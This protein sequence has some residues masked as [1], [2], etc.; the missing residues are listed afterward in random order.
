MP[1]FLKQ[2]LATVVGLFLFTA[3]SVA[4]LTTLLFS[5]AFLSR[6]SAPEVA[7][8]SLLTLDLSEPIS[9]GRGE[10]GDV[11][12]EVISGAPPTRSIA[13]RTV[14]E[15]IERGA[16]DDRI[17]GLYLHGNLSLEGLGSGYA[18]LQEV[19]QA[20]QKFRD[21]G[22]PI[23]AYDTTGWSERDY[24]LT[25]VANKILL[26]PA[27]QLEINGLSSETTF[28]TGALQ[29]YGIGVQP[30]RAGKYKSA[31]E[32]F[33]RTSRSPESE[34][35]T[36]A[37]LKDLWNEFVST[38]AKSRN[39]TPRQ[40]QAIADTKGILLP[41][42]AQSAKLIDQLA[43]EDEV[44]AELQKVT[45]EKDNDSF[46]Q[47]SVD[48]YAEIVAEKDR[49]SGDRIAV[50]YAEGNI[51]SGRGGVGTIGG[52]SLAKL[53][54]DLRQDDDIKAVVLRV[55]SPGGSATASDL[56]AREV[57]LTK[58]EKPVIVSMGSYAA[59][60]GYQISANAN[61]IFAAPTTITGSIGV[62][63]LLPNFQKIAS[64]NGITWDTVKTGRFADINTISR[65]K[66]PQELTILQSS[67]NRIYNRFLSLVS[68]SRSIPRTRVAEIAQG[69]VWSGIEAK[70][71]GL[72]DE[73]GGLEDA[74]QAAA[75]A[76]SLGDKW[77]LD[78]Y[79]RPRSFEER[80]FSRFFSQYLP[81][82]TANDPL[83]Q[84]IQ[85]IREDWETL[86]SMNDPLG[87]Y[88]RLPFNPRIE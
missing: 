31:V 17:A 82:A 53:L 73:I 21:A 80:L 60:G 78:E 34:E 64:T 81:Q 26:N 29:K 88:S 55:N 23:F 2:V 63:G 47:I 71:I 58:K 87:L 67:V 33:T 86:R 76:A 36:Q 9:D 5:L 68:T 7:K 50:I 11:I 8:D 85:Q 66:N 84:E 25:S 37:L 83:S 51:V 12:S 45:G 46:R 10:R 20:L 57:L 59:S 38:A 41:E 62:F 18:T 6:E 40:L 15:A 77:Q 70:K 22:K 48:E 79:P 27:G 56:I 42:Q 16:T 69:R 4:G 54:K 75:K 24:Y 19:R 74:I 44:I 43:Y 49:R 35:E 61:R 32:P 28:F 13:L 52:D 65:P 72:V 30:I 39:L 3:L 1:N 14:L